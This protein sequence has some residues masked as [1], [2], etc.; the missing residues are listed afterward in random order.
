[1]I[2]AM[3][4]ASLLALLVLVLYVPSAHPPERFVEQLRTEYANA[5]VF[6]GK[7]E[8][9]RMLSRAMS[10]QVSARQ[11]SPV[12]SSKDA[13]PASSVNA[14]VSREMASVNQRLFNNPYFRSIDALLL[15]ASFR[16]AMLLEWLP[17]LMAFPVAA[18]VDGCLV[19]LV[20]AKEFLHHS[21]EMFAF[22]ACL[23]I[24]TSCATVLAF[25][26][27][28]T[29]HPLVVPC[30]PVIIGTLMGAAIRDFHLRA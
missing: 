6:W 27:P 12:P 24:L 1:M 5:A 21:P 8:G 17:W 9:T 7:D 22:Y 15:L 3:A 25:V 23:A 10:M 20:K 14:A 18:L 19:R 30:V 13:A 28:I 11:A 4:A 26:L 29:L 2:R 16:L